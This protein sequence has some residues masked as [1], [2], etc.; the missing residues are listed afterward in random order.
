[1]ARRTNS[2]QVLRSAFHQQISKHITK[3]TGAG[4]TELS[5]FLMQCFGRPRCLVSPDGVFWLLSQGG[6]TLEGMR[7]DLN[8]R[9]AA[10]PLPSAIVPPFHFQPQYMFTG[11]GSF[12]V[13]TST[14]KLSYTQRSE[15]GD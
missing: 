7:L 12:P 5:W 10:I 13:P 8:F 2:P 6:E 3:K 4:R 15:R 1:M 14:A 9:Q 11:I